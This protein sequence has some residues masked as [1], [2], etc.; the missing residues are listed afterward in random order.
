M[1]RKRIA[2][3]VFAGFLGLSAL[4]SCQKDPSPVSTAPIHGEKLV[5]FYGC[6]HE[7]G[8]SGAIENNIEELMEGA[9]PF[10]NSSRNIV[11]CLQH[12]N[13]EGPRLS[14]LYRD[15][16]G[17]AQSR[18]ITLEEMS[19]WDENS[20][21]ISSDTLRNI[22]QYISK[23][24]VAKEN[25]LI[26]SSHATGWL[27]AGSYNLP[28]RY[29]PVPTS[30]GQELG[31]DF[32]SVY[33]MELTTFAE[34][35]P[36]C[37]DAIIIDACLSGGIEVAYELK[38]KCK[39]IV[40]SPTEILSRGMVYETMLEHLF[41]GN[42]EAIGQDYI[43]YY[44]NRNGLQYATCSVVDCTQ[45]DTLAS[46]CKNIFN[47][48]RENIDNLNPSEIQRY[49]R[50][51]KTWFYD[52]GH[53]IEK[54]GVSEKEWAEFENALTNCMLYRGH[55]P[56]FFEIKIEHYSGFSTYLQSMGNNVLDTHYKKLA[57]NKATDYIQ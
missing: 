52:F 56:Y 31:N 19:Q 47:K 29:T 53:I 27:P 6:G 20:V 37:F 43:Q 45:L 21:C 51:D 54:I 34:K 1:G 48:Y 35:L 39:K 9:L 36:L 55:T 32:V 41:S 46:I 28:D 42:I 12:S 17:K 23:Y 18:L 14:R 16:Q 50:G 4:F 15:A 10:I 8:L 44:L 5:L 57:W 3:F 24:Y 22:L 26:F 11:L 40:F 25:Y 13:G 38:D 2:C 49:Y 30:I 7:N 33:E